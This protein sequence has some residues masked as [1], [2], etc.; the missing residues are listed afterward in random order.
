MSD[1]ERLHVDLCCGLGGWSAPFEAADGWRSVGIDIR[2]DLEADVVA[3]VRHLP[4]ACRPTLLTMSPPCTAFSRYSMPWL[5]EPEPDTSLVEAC[6]AAVQELRPEWWVLE[7][8]CGLKQF[9]GVQ[10]RKRV[11]PFYLWGE[12]PPF[13]VATPDGG[14]MQV[15]GEHPEER[16]RIPFEIGD[17]LRGSVEVFG[18]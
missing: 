13:D 11:G 1:V 17:A 2:E 3:D 15:S 10:E 7:N 14:K 12:F 9:S 16:A 4:L 18:E 5:E 8:V 6:L